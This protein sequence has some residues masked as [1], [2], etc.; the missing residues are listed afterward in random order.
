MALLLH[1][2]YIKVHLYIL[3]ITCRGSM[4]VYTYLYNNALQPKQQQQYY[5]I[6]Q[7]NFI[8]TH[9]NTNIYYIICTF[10]YKILVTYLCLKLIE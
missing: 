2:S 10:V 6:A 8:S 4:K 9:K 3:H 5:T 7:H 1:T